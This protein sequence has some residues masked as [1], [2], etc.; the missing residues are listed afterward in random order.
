MQIG[1]QGKGVTLLLMSL[2]IRLREQT[3]NDL[4]SNRHVNDWSCRAVGLE[5]S[6]TVYARRIVLLLAEV[7]TK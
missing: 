7:D 1:S 6:L 4:P 5:D 3:L 2:R